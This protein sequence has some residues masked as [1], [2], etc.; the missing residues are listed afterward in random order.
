[1]T[2]FWR[3]LFYS[4]SL[5]HAAVAVCNRLT[6]GKSITPVEI[7]HARLINRQ[8]DIRVYADDGRVYILS[9]REEKG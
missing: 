6:Q 3:R 8:G 7:K 5:L 9:L 4:E 1:M 2:L